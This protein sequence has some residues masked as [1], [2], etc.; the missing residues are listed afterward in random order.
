M[1]QWFFYSGFFGYFSDLYLAKFILYVGKT[2]E[3]SGAAF[4]MG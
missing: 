1:S 2:Q 4:F 3:K